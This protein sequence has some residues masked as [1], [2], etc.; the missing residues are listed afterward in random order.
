MN[1]LHSLLVAF[2]LAAA[3]AAHAEEITLSNGE[4][5]PYLAAQSPHGGVGSRIVSEAFALEG[6]KVNFV[7]RPW[8]RAFLEAQFGE[9]QGSI[10]WGPGPPGSDR[11]RRFYFSDPVLVGRSVFFHLRSVAFDWQRPED[12][13]P[14]RIGGTLGYKYAFENQPGIRIDRAGTDEIGFTK[15]LAG[16]FQLFPSDLYAGRDVLK[17]HFTP[18]QVALITYHP[19]PYMITQYHLIMSKQQAGNARYI[20]LFNRGL[21]KLK[22]SGKYASYLAQLDN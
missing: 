6:I 13:V 7:F 18:A 12:L 9:V 8:Q 1:R 2:L 16:R 22:D 5:H 14:L 3:F 15:L 4:W 21:K 17:R 20:A 19:R 10:L 11:G